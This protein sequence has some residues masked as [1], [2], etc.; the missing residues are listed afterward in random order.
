MFNYEFKFKSN[1]R[2]DFEFKLKLNF[3]FNFEFN[4]TPT[5]SFSCFVSVFRIT[6]SEMLR[7]LERWGILAILVSMPF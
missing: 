7:S 3:R 6:P 2:F 4:D 1:F 5:Q